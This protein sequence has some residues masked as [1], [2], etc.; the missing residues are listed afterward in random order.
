MARLIRIGLIECLDCGAFIGGHVW[1]AEKPQ[2]QV[3][4][5]CGGEI[6]FVNRRKTHRFGQ[7][8][9]DITSDLYFQ[10]A[11]LR[12]E[13]TVSEAKRLEHTYH[14]IEKLEENGATPRVDDTQ[15]IKASIAEYKF[16]EERGIAI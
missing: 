8:S 11:P 10:N 14:K 16:K 2:S 13:Q 7:M 6:C 3:C 12:G 9:D 15:E 1:H 4:P 5:K